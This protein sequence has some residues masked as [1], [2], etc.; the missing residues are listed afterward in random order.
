MFYHSNTRTVG[1][2]RKWILTHPYDFHED[3]T[4]LYKILKTELIGNDIQLS[5]YL[6]GLI[7]VI[8]E[9]II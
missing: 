2:L 9:S 8:Q 4:H 7:K 5:K 6:L 1:F 3:E